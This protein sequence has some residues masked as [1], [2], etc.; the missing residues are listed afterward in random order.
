MSRSRE[1]VDSEQ[2]IDRIAHA[3]S[4][5]E[6]SGRWLAAVI[7]VFAAV[8]VMTVVQRALITDGAMGWIITSIH[9]LIVVV[10]VPVLTVKTIREWRTAQA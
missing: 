8:A 10:V 4:P 6:W 9:G 5:A 2:L 3:F 1:S 7:V